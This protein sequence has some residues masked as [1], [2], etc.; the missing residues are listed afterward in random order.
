MKPQ[1]AHMVVIVIYSALLRLSA[2]IWHPA[3]LSG[4]IYSCNG[5]RVL[6]TI[7]LRCFK[8]QKQT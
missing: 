7:F 6:S 5:P 1:V 3:R 8:N 4:A 2:Q